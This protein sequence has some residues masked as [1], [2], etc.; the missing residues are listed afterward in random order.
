MIGNNI[1][2]LPAWLRKLETEYESFDKLTPQAR[3]TLKEGLKK[4]AADNPDATIAIPVYNEEKNITRTLASFARMNPKCR[5]E[6]IVVNN[7]SKD[8][9]KEILT[10]LGVKTVDE[11]RQSISHARQAGLENARGEYFL[12]A[13]GDSIYPDGWID[14][15]VEALKNPEVACV[16]GTYSF[17]PGKGSSRFVLAMYEIVTRLLF[18]LRRKKM[19]FFN[20]L[21]FNFAFR[22]E[23]GL[24]AGGFN[25]T[26]QRW[27]DGWMAMTLAQYGKI[28]RITDN[29][30]R[31][32]TSDRRL[33]YDGGLFKAILKRMTKE[34]DRYGNLPKP[35][36]ELENLKTNHG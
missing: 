20:V 9:T 1:F 7:N 31:V 16:Y 13:D 29:N 8:R 6:L 3:E 12:N 14:T 35:A 30:V 27:S 11:P 18:L 32:W 33:A 34:I 23:D 15:Y 5:A 4:Y 28:E 24:K 17:I 2:G 21:G 19:D 25:T 10:I 36:Q 26:R 22:R